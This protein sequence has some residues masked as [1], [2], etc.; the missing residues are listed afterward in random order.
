MAFP[1]TPII[2]DGQRANENPLSNGGI[3][4]SP[5]F[6]G[7]FNGQLLSNVLTSSGTGWFSSRTTYKIPADGEIYGTI[8]TTGTDFLQFF[9]V[10]GP[11]TAGLTCYRANWQPTP[12]Q[13]I[14][15]RIVNNTLSATVATLAA[16]V[17]GGDQVG[18]RFVGNTFTAFVNGIEVNSTTDS[19]PIRQDGF[20]GVGAFFNT[21]DGFTAVGGGP[22]AIPPAVVKPPLIYMRRN[23]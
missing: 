5:I 7:D 6:P 3:W 1:N 8:A 23:L 10:L 13:V 4:S 17:N 9:R 15:D 2:D 11:N 20:L 22:I 16:T 19:A 21:G 12:N 18:I 14:I